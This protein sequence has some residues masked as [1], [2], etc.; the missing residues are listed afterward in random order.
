M[1]P[2]M[3]REE[4]KHNVDADIQQRLQQINRFAK[5]GV[6]GEK[7]QASTRIYDALQPGLPVV[8]DFISDFYSPRK[9]EEDKHIASM[10]DMVVQLIL[11]V[12]R[13]VKKH[14]ESV[15]LALANS[16]L[17]DFPNVPGSCLLTR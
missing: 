3:P 2:T 15:A 16:F 14:D 1:T 9:R 11:V 8:L 10:M 6:F 12:Y 13:D 7:V 17:S 5:N 4:N